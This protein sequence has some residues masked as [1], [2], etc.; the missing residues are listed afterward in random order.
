VG[1]RRESGEKRNRGL[2]NKGRPNVKEVD[3]A[4]GDP[5]KMVQRGEW[6]GRGEGKS[7]RGLRRARGGYQKRRG[8]MGSRSPTESVNGDASKLGRLA[9]GV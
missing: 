6:K 3:C 2:Q 4:L 5:G 9:D 7:R 8:G 1:R